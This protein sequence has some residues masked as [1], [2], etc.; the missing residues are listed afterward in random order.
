MK[1]SQLNPDFRVFY[2][3]TI[4]LKDCTALTQ[5][6]IVIVDPPLLG[7]GRPKRYTCNISWWCRN[8]RKLYLSASRRI[9]QVLVNGLFWMRLEMDAEASIQNLAARAEDEKEERERKIR[10]DRCSD[11]SILSA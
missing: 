7:D 10:T 8:T 9:R 6:T 11:L 5:M 2:T 1:Q 3:V 4:M